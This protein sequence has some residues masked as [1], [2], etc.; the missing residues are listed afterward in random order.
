MNEIERE[1][2]KIMGKYIVAD[3][4]LIIPERNID[5]VEK[6]IRNYITGLLDKVIPEYAQNVNYY[7]GF[8]Q[9]IDEINK[10]IA[11]LKGESI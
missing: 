4:Q 5:K 10:N 11:K 6:D 3:G 2:A 1:I 9:C 7:F 8:N